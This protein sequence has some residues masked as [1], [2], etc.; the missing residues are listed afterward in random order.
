MLQPSCSC[1][2]GT[3]KNISYR[4][5][6][7]IVPNNR[8]TAEVPVVV[9]PCRDADAR[10]THQRKLAPVSACSEQSPTPGRRFQFPP[11]PSRFPAIASYRGP[12]IARLLADATATTTTAARSQSAGCWMPRGSHHLLAISMRSNSK[13]SAES[14]RARYRIS[15]FDQDS[16]P[17][18]DPRIV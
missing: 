9:D 8:G 11:L 14:T 4:V 5:V 6:L 10:P 18:S 16:R 17:P 12:P 1:H 2:A 15:S 7:W 13:W 3:V